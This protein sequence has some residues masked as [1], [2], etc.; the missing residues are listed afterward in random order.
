MMKNEY[1]YIKKKPYKLDVIW[2][3]LNKERIKK[4]KTIL[5]IFKK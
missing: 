4:I 1:M 3:D 2:V 5:R